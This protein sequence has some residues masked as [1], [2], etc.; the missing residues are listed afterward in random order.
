MF[1]EV[2]ETPNPKTLKFLLEEN[3]ITNGKSYSFSNKV[4][5][6]N[7]KLAGKLFEIEN[8]TMV[9]ISGDFI[10]VSVEEITD[11]SKVKHKVLAYITDF[12]SL[13]I[14]VIENYKE[15][16]LVENKEYISSSEEDK[17]IVDTIVELFDERIR[18]AVAMD[19]GDI[20]FRDF[21]DG[22]VYIA[23][24]GACS[25]CPS[26]SVTLK[27]GIENMLKYYVPSVKSVVDINE[28]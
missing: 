21:K 18:P 24:Q 14:D 23:M 6:K 11:W 8:I 13:G 3:I 16:D 7:S 19:G 22:V 17:E 28:I 15:K 10:S 4:D 12:I 27:H 20:V 2:L 5:A 1:I 9:Y 26:A 25:G